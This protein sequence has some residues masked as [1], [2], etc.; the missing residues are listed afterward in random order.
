MAGI[1]GLVLDVRRGACGEVPLP[2]SKSF[3]IRALLLAAWAQGHTRLK[4]LLD[5]DDTAVMIESLKRLGVRI[6]REGPDCLVWGADGLLSFSGTEKEPVECFVGNS[7]LTVRTLLPAV[8]A[9]LSAQEGSLVLR[10]V[11]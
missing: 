2:G 5:S 4:G 3:S 8:V 9:A 10:G 1:S 11:P 6:E 7:G